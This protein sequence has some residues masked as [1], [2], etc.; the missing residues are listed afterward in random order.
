MFGPDTRDFGRVK[1]KKKLKRDQHT[2][3]KSERQR[4]TQKESFEGRARRLNLKSVCVFK[5][6]GKVRIG[7]KTREQKR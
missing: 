5:G 4:S 2:K 7:G 6:K 3:I 1:K